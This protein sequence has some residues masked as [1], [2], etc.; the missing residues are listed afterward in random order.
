MSDLL[1]IGASGVRAY[2][3]ALTT[4]SENIANS[5][6]DGYSRR[7][8]DLAE[9][10]STSSDIAQRKITNGNGVIVTGT[11]RSVDLYRNAGVRTASSDLARTETSGTWLTAIEG[12]L[13]ENKLGS[14]LT[15]FFNAVQTL[16]ADPSSIPARSVMIEAARS[17][18]NAFAATGTGLDRA[19]TELDATA[20]QSAATLSSL[21]QTLAKVNDGL[22]RTPAKSATAAQLGDQRDNLLERMS[23]I[24]DLGVTIDS[25]GRATVRL[26]G[27]SGALFVSNGG[28]SGRLS[29]L[30]NAQGAV[31]LTVDFNTT[32]SAVTPSGGV[33]GGMVDGAQRIA[34]ARFS[35]NQIATDFTSK[36]N[37][38]QSQGRDLDGQPGAAFFA[39]GTTATDIAVTLD[40]P[41][42]IAA[43]GPNGSIRDAS[44]LTEFQAVRGSAAFESR[45]TALVA[46]NAAALEQKNL[47]AGAQSSIRDGA[48][49]ARDAVSGVNLD[50]EAVELLRFQQAYQASSRVIQVAKDTMQTLLDIR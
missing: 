4:I 33:L 8:T 24:S 26:G 29:Y 19:A 20:R 38:L 18:A 9:V 50:T 27:Q 10:T 46:G 44:N 43:A 49:A 14:Q 15:G 22:T 6:V 2:Q 21:A 41:R 3:G 1:T 30:R 45:T 28:E 13:T 40:D 32:R 39:T 25:L 17:A 23:A 37:Q 7:T 16:A 42:S 11:S 31:A 36:I 12:S 35:L 34:D 48:V 47:V 5:G